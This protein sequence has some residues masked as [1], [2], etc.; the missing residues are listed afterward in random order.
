MA[1]KA[2]H[3]DFEDGA[4][5]HIDGEAMIAATVTAHTFRGGLLQIEC[6]WFANGG[7]QSVWI[8]EWRLS[9]AAEE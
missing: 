3:T 6:Q 2:F 9:R 4:R 1:G 7:L 5:V 8:E